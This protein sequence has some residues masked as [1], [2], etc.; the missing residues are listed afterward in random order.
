MNGLSRLT[1]A[2]AGTVLRRLAVAPLTCGAALIGW[3]DAVDPHGAE[4]RQRLANKREAETVDFTFS[5]EAHGFGLTYTMTVGRFA[6][7][8]IAE[9]FLDCHKLASPATDDALEVAHLISLALQHGMPVSA[10]VH[11]VAR[12]EDGRPCTLIGRVADLLAEFEGAA[13]P[14]VGFY[15]FVP[16]PHSGTG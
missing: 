3:A 10:L 12:F 4:R 6:D 1:H 2:A 16:E 14:A 13:R 11:A 7:G 5:R 8:R 15:P 9:V